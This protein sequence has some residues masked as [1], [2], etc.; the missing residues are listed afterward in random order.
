MI[1]FGSRQ[2][3]NLGNETETF[4]RSVSGVAFKPRQPPNLGNETETSLPPCHLAPPSP[5]QPPNLGNETETTQIVERSDLVAPSRQPPNL[6]NETETRHE[7]F[8]RKDR[9]TRQPPN[10]GNETETS[11]PPPRR[12]Q[13]SKLANHPISATRL[14]LPRVVLEG[15]KRSPSP[16]TQSRQ[17]D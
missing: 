14:K 1:R 16:T 5:R 8:G 4:W 2:P 13:H 6:G 10:L 3:P 12:N 17:R 7:N 15:C 11:V 9:Q